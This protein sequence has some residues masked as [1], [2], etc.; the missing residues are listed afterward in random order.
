MIPSHIPITHPVNVTVEHSF[1]YPLPPFL[2]ACDIGH[3]DSVTL[4]TPVNV[5]N[6]FLD[7]DRSPPQVFPVTHSN[8]GGQR[9]MGGPYTLLP[10]LRLAPRLK[11]RTRHC[12]N[13]PLNQ[14]DKFPN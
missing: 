14:R 5:I 10:N 7:I 8:T 1:N 12:Q 9:S 4:Q 11:K 2:H 6:L 13:L 3:F